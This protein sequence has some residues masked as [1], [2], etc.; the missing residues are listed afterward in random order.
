MT[1]GNM[2][3]SSRLTRILLL[4]SSASSNLSSF[5]IFVFV[6]RVLRAER[7]EDSAVFENSLTPVVNM[8]VN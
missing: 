2:R 3:N 4:M 7:L 6:A 1:S 5:A 8:I